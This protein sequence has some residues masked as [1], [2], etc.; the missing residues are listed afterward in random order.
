MKTC[1]KQTIS[2]VLSL[3]TALS[4]FNANGY[5]LAGYI[6]IDNRFFIQA[7]QFEEQDMNNGPSLVLEPELYHISNDGKSTYTF[8]PFYRYD[9]YDQNRQHFDVRQLDWL[10]AENEWEVSVGISK[11]FWGVAESNHLVDIINQ[12]DSIEDIDGEDKLGQPML[13]L[14]LFKSWGSL[15]LYYMPYFRERTFP[16]KTGRFRSNINIESKTFYESSSEEWHPDFAVRYEHTIDNWDIGISN[17]YG[18]SR[19]P[20]FITRL[21]A[22][23]D[24]VLAPQYDLINQTSLDVQYTT[25]SWLWKLESIYRTGYDCPFAAVTGGFEYTFYDT[26]GSGYDVGVLLEYQ[27][28]DRSLNAPITLA[29]ND[30]FSALRIV[31][32]NVNES[33]ILLGGSIDTNTGAIINLV[34]ASTRINNNWTAELRV[35]FAA[36]V[37]FDAPESFLRQDDHVKFTL[38]RYF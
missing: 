30:V 34:E 18:T 32:N 1:S 24:I 26:F 13:Q 11:V 25:E 14:G 23:N 3:L 2:S 28:D 9:S 33:E 10:Y 6:G 38:S 19:E 35:S 15:R 4:S 22:D 31:L 5:E 17:F 8:K 36:D 16:S 21:N 7:P 29:D 27:F 20:I 12:T 37:Q